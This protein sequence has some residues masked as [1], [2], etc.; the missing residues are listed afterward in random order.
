[1]L[2]IMTSALD[3]EYVRPQCEYPNLFEQ[4]TTKEVVDELDNQ[5]DFFS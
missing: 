4:K 5:L 2:D 3:S 1:M